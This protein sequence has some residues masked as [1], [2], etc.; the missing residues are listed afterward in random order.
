MTVFVNPMMKK[1][2]QKMMKKKLGGARVMIG[3]GLIPER[4]LEA[5]SDGL[6]EEK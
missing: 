5:R 2:K 4:D 6:I 3:S 1:Q